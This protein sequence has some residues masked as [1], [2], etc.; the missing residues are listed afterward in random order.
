MRASAS[1]T[2]AG[3]HASRSPTA[4][5]LPPRPAAFVDQVVDTEGG[6]SAGDRTSSGGRTAASWS[7]A[8]SHGDVLDP[9]APRA[10][11]RHVVRP[12]GPHPVDP[13][14]AGQP[15]PRRV[16]VVDA[17]PPRTARACDHTPMP[18]SCRT[19]AAPAPTRPPAATSTGV[20]TSSAAPAEGSPPPATC[21]PPPSRAR[22]ARA[23]GR[24][25]CRAAR[26]RAPPR[27]DR[28][29]SSAA[30]RADHV[31]GPACSALGAPAPQPHSCRADRSARTAA[32]RRGR[33]ALWLRRATERAASAPL[34][35]PRLDHDGY[36][37]GRP[38]S[39][40]QGPGHH[41]APNSGPTSGLVRKSPRRPARRR[42]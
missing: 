35:R 14:A 25:G 15:A 21:P 18:H 28:A 13:R 17:A 11:D 5:S 12:I 16:G 7:T 30:D 24:A 29:V 39:T 34:P 22:P 19:A 10:G 20:S 41:G 9:R 1:L 31:V 26:W 3:L 2:P 4:P 8:T 40:H 32:S 38:S 6:Q 37:S 33:A 27:L 42:R 36:G 23:A